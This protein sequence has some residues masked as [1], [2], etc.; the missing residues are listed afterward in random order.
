VLSHEE[1]FARFSAEPP[2]LLPGVG[3]KTAAALEEM[4][5]VTIDA[6]AA[7]APEALAARFG[8]RMGPWLAHR[9]R[10]EDDSPVSEVRIA[11]S[12]SR[13]TTFDFD[14]ADRVELERIL[15][16]LVGQLCSGLSK[17]GRRGRTI[18]IKIRLDDFTT[19]TRARTLPEPVN[20]PER[21]GS[22]ARE[23]L[24]E[25]APSRPVRL[26]GVRVA[27]FD[28]ERHET[29]AQLALPVD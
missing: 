11:V 2:G 28:H 25:Y 12:E 27:S 9:A 16:G 4:G 22:V 8:P 29:G 6:L 5:I 20:E 23:L 24:R 15:D 21:V 14:V 10:F 3:P 26:L 1:A 17:Q 13:E 18:G 19:A 7:A